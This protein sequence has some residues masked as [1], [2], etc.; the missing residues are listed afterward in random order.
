LSIVEPVSPRPYQLGRRQAAADET[1]A[2]IIAAGRKLLDRKG[3]LGGFTVDAVAREAGVARMTVYHQFGSRV[4]L[5]EALFDTLAS[6]RDADKLVAA[7]G[8]PDPLVG[9]SEFVESLGRSWSSDRRIVRRL[10]GLAAVDPEFGQVWQA[11]EELRR[12]GLRAIV[13]RVAEKHGGP[14]PDA[15]DLAVDVLYALV[16]FE[17][18]DAIAGTA[19]PFARAASEIYRLALAALGVDQR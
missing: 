16:S 10:Q 1:R 14:A 8:R 6:H 7:I 19:R 13:E 18:F 15:V 3:G 11:R 9:L 4:G 12:N 5:L 2:R 17:T